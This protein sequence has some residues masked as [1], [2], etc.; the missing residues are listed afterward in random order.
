[1]RPERDP[2]TEPL[3]VLLIE[4]NPGDVGLIT[5]LLDEVRSRG[6]LTRLVVVPNL[7]EG[8]E[9]LRSG[10]FAVVLLDLGLPESQGLDTVHRLRAHAARL[11]ALVVLSGL[12]DEEVAVSA[13]EAGAQDYLVK[14][15]VDAPAMARTIRYALG[16]HHAE[17]VL[18][19]ELERSRELAAE[20]AGRHKAED[21]SESLRRLFDERGEM[22]H[23]LAHEVRQPL[24]NASTALQSA[25]AAISASG[26]SAEPRVRQPLEHAQQVLDQ[27]IGTL[28]NALAAAVLLTA[29]GS[30]E[31]SETDLDTLIGLVVQ[32]IGTDER[33]RVRVQAE[34]QLRTVQLQPSLMRLALCNLL[35][36][37]LAYSAPGSPVELRVG[38]AD[39]PPA[40]W[41]EI[42][43]EGEGIPAALVP[44]VFDKGTRG[45]RSRAG[46]G[47][48]LGLYIVRR[49][50]ELH[51]G[52]IE[53]SSNEPCGTVVRISIPQAVAW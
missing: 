3:D 18:S 31:K 32:D 27:V 53:L 5:M 47:A 48:G 29:G 37:A 43:D 20:R 35:L 39:D 4:D 11:P 45:A 34:S 25:S 7:T 9:R 14:G 40:L 2:G 36:N 15:H 10:N 38:D 6:L 33:A 1:M 49:V 52:R 13:L 51:H 41:F 30:F 19:R 42:R 12:S 24:N 46:T 8:V 22:L 26:D 16:R 28:N 23:L 17:Q 50:V 44:T 21:E